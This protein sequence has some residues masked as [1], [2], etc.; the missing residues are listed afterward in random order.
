MI[1]LK[2]RDLGLAFFY[3]HIFFLVYVFLLN[4][5]KNIKNLYVCIVLWFFFI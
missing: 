3:C 1:M 2:K 5:Q 4:P